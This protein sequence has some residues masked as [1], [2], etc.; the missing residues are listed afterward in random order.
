MMKKTLKGYI[1]GIL[2][3]MLLFG[4]IAYAANTTT[5]YNVRANGVKIVVD[6][7]ELH[8]TDVNG[9]KVEPIIYNET[10]IQGQ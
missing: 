2:S 10:V 9:N 8:P 5:L 6:G 7:K 3:S 4:I 1:L